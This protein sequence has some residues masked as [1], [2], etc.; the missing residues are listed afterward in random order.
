MLGE[1]RPVLREPHEAQ[2]RDRARQE[3]AKL[4]IRY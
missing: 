2:R 3:G 4:S 1:A